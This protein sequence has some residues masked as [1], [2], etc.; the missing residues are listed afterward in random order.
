MMKKFSLLLFCAVYFMG[1]G[2]HYLQQED[3]GKLVYTASKENQIIYYKKNYKFSGD[4]V[5]TI[6][7][8]YLLKVGENSKAHPEFLYVLDGSIEKLVKYNSRIISNGI[9]E[10]NYGKGDL[11][12]VNISTK[13]VESDVNIEYLPITENLKSGDIIETY[14]E[15]ES[16]LPETGISF[17]LSEIAFNANNITCTIDVP[18]K[19]S[20]IYK[21][22][23]DDKTPS[24][25]SADGRTNYTIDWGNYTAEV[26]DYELG[27]RARRPGIIAAAPGDR[28][29]GSN[30]PSWISLGRWYLDLIGNRLKSDTVIRAQAE[31][32]VKGKSTSKDKLDAIV[33]YCQKNIRYEQVYLSRGEFIPHTCREILKK[34]YGDC[35]DY[36]VAIYTLARSLGIM[37]DLALTF[38]GRGYE[39][40]DEIPASQF[41]HMLVHYADNGID[42]WYDGTNRTGLPDVVSSDLINQKALVLNETNSRIVTINESPENL[43][44]IG[45]A[46]QI[47]NSDLVGTLTISLKNQFA[48]DFF[49][50]ASEL[51][52]VQ[53]NEF[54]IQFLKDNLNRSI[55]I[56]KLNWE[57]NG[58]KFTIT[59][60]C[61][62][63]NTSIAVG[64]ACYSSLSKMFPCLF[65]CNVK[66]RETETFYFPYYNRVSIDLKL[67]DPQ[68]GLNR[69][70]SKTSDD[71][72]WKYNYSIAPG[73]FNGSSLKEFTAAFSEISK[74][75]NKNAKIIK[76][77]NK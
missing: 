58:S 46:L 72:G 7:T 38:R 11:S 73:P 42:Y 32:I 26:K 44:S 17:S 12:A 8:H 62:L 31:A 4:R 18:E 74:D 57:K 69:Q 70:E 25:N 52:H 64:N 36:S 75:F 27:K 60:V 1:C 6:G 53:M 56:K 47:S 71:P 76:Q 43:L 40:V 63:P 51:N 34:N 15:H 5:L 49:Y 21:V 3:I 41:N 68:S 77:G 29:N 2:G 35:K 45:G 39:F 22:L 20:L 59:A 16:S 66:I 55:S 48:I 19:D 54:L 28:K 13:T 24:V 50:A 37:A 33:E 61:E 9:D 65:P 30:V 14:Y 10:K 67:S 23:N